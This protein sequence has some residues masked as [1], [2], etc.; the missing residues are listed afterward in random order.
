LTDV[1]PMQRHDRVVV[2]TIRLDAT[3]PA[4]LRVSTR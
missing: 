1:S 2:I 4:R 3:D